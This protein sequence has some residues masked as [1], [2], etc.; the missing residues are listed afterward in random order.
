M[1]GWSLRRT[2]P[3]YYNRGRIQRPTGCSFSNYFYPRHQLLPTPPRLSRQHHSLRY[4]LPAAHPLPPRH[5]TINVPPRQ[6]TNNGLAA[7][8]AS[9]APRILPLGNAQNKMT[10]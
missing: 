10:L 4:M 5:A 9:T 1:F 2:R 3:Y 8:M 6:T 7:S